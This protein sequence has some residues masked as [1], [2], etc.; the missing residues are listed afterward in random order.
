LIVLDTNVISEPARLIMEPN[1]RIWYAAQTPGSLYATA[2]SLAEM[3]YGVEKLPEGRRKTEIRQRMDAVF[4]QY[5][6][7]RILPFEERAA[8]AYGLVVASA[9]ANGR[10]ILMADGQLASIAK[11]HG[12]TVATRDTVPFEAAGVPVIN[13]W[14][15]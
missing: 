15:A 11:I 9:R 1:V 5:F 13:P 14:K 4:E 6:R 8:R 3:S 10:A 7:G 2:V 12:L